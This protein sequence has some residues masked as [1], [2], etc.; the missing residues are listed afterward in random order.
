MKAAVIAVGLKPM[1]KRVLYL[2][3]GGRLSEATPEADSAA[4]T[5]VHNPADPPPTVGGRLLSPTGGYRDDTALIR[6]ADVVTFTGDPLPAELH[7]VG[8]PTLELS[9]SCTNRYNDLF[10]RISQVDVHG[11]SR[12]VSDGYRASA[13]AR[14]TVGIELDPVAHTF[15]AGSRI[16]LLIAGGSHPRFLRNLGTGESPVSGTAVATAKHIVHLSGA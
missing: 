16:R 6:R 10:V 11:G 5:F 8:A 14:G 9:H 7:A 15:P 12:N 4:A 2:Q 1:P 3:P 13:P